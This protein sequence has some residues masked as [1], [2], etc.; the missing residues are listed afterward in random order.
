MTGIRLALRAPTRLSPVTRCRPL[1]VE[2]PRVVRVQSISRRFPAVVAVVALACVWWAADT[3][4][5]PATPSLAFVD[6]DRTLRV[7]GAD[8]SGERTLATSGGQTAVAVWDR[9]WHPSWSP[10]GSRVAYVRTIETVVAAPR[11]ELLIARADGTKTAA[12][13]TLAGAGM[14]FDVRWSPDG[15]R[16]A[17]ALFTPNPAGIVTWWSGVSGRWDVYLINVDGSGLRPVAPV[18]PYYASG[19]DGLDWSPD[20]K[21]LAFVTDAGGLPG[22][23]TVAIAGVAVPTRVS[24]LDVTASAPR[25]SPDGSSIAFVGTPIQP[26]AGY[27]RRFPQLWTVD[28][29]GTDVRPLPAQTFHPP[30][31]SPDSRWL[32][33]ACVEDT[34]GINIIRVDGRAGRTL[35]APNHA[36]DSRPS[37]SRHDRIAFIR[38]DEHC[39]LYTLWTM[40]P[41]GTEQRQITDAGSI[42]NGF[43]WS[44]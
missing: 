33:Y 20:G 22:I 32:A 16:L 25:W 12:V 31:W 30:T 18:H 37:W 38:A 3:P 36:Q 6:D 2:S 19:L 40:K 8:G 35:T 39:C 41:D 42:Y 10:D 17:F 21:K 7:V 1:A 23:Y 27:V 5:Q 43:A 11:T 34:C 28:A 26:I 13:L 44:R 4:A 29:D 24:P 9:L 15:H 14:I